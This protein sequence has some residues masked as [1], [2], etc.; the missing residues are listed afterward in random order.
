MPVIARDFYHRPALDVAR[1]LLGCRLVRRQAGAR[2]AGIIL[3]TEAYQGE[4][5][6]GCHASAGKTPRTSVMYGPPGYAYVYFTYGMHWL[7]NAVTD[8]E[9]VPAAVLIRA[10]Q[11]VEGVDLM[12]KNRPYR[13]FQKGWTDGPAKLTQALG[14]NGDCNRVDLC[15]PAGGLWIEPGEAV[16]A[17]V[18]EQTARIG[19]N[20]VPEPWKSIPW[21]FVLQEGAIRGS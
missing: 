4:E 7:L 5:D 14:I 6:L 15:D 21:R 10:N 1:D 12:A 13:A 2:L 8:R 9:G 11:P 16:S 3:E 20:A 17:E 18:I 19:L